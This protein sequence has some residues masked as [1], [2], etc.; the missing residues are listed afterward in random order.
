METLNY[1][2]VLIVILLAALAILGILLFVQRRRSGKSGRSYYIDALHAMVEG[3]KEDAFKLLTTAV[4]MGE[5]STDAYLQLGI[6]LRERGQPDKALQLHKGLMVRRDLEGSEEKSVIM[7]IAEDLESLGKTEKAIQMLENLSRKRKDAET[8]LFL[9][10]LYH[11][12]GEYDRA[13]S[14]IKDLGKIE[15][16][17][18]G[19]VRAG[20]LAT[21]SQMLMKDGKK[22]EAR[23]MLERARKEH[24]DSIP[25]LYLS[26]SL[27]MQEEDL[28][29]AARFWEKLLE[30][31]IDCF[32]EVLP[33]LEKTLYSSGEFQDLERI[34][35]KLIKRYP[36]EPAVI[37]A[38]A[39]FYEKKG[40]RDKAV[41][42]LEEER[43]ILAKNAV[44]SAKLASLYLQNGE[45]ESARHVLEEIDINSKT[46]AAYICGSCGDFAIY[47]LTYCN[48]CSS[49][50][51]FKKAYEG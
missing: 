5:S 10:K 12:R 50:G 7:A 49:F 2:L 33:F 36:E 32:C 51:S 47:P 19:S 16:G 13:I 44:A 3:R 42:I 1:K 31:D 29:S 22:D 28:V 43:S 39:T 23:K 18:G 35:D 14:A 21:V 11:Q 25:A 37:T 9:H 8:L 48:A 17:Y 30:I 20:Y 27:A 6:L 26:A 40:E 4:K 24:R 45:Q 15:K 41:R 38:L 34:L 46:D